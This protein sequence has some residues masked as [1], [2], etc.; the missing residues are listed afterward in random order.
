MELLHRAATKSCEVDPL[1]TR[2]IKSNLE[3]FAPIL[4]DIINASLDSAIFPEDAKNALVRPLLKK[5]NLQ[6]ISENYRPVSNLGFLSK[7]I[8]RAACDQILNHAIST[9]NMEEYQSAYRQKHC[10]ETALLRIKTNNI[11]VD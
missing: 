7:L 6:L 11:S 8:E 3:F 2:L 4:C 10:T 5:V 9:G 1:P